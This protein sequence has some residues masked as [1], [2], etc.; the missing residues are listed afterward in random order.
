[1][2]L[3]GRAKRVRIYVNEGDVV[4]HKPAHLAILEFLRAHDTA[5]ATVLRAIEGFGGSGQI[6]TA[7]VVDAAF[8]LPIVIEWIDT[9]ERVAR[10]LPG[11]KQLV[12]RGLVT[13]DDTEVV[14]FSPQAVRDLPASLTV[15][16]VMVKAP[17]TVAADASIVGVV[18][19]LLEHEGHGAV[20]VV[21]GGVPVGIIT[22]S[23]F[24]SRGGAPIR[25]KLFTSL[26]EPER[27]LEL[28]RLGAVARTARDLM[29]APVTVRADAPLVDAAATMARKHLKRMPVVDES[30]R[31][32]GLLRRLDLLRTVA[33]RI[34]APESTAPPIEVATDTPVGSV[35]RSDV[36]AVHPDTPID[37][38]MQAVIAT[39]VYCAIVVDAD[40]RPLGIV[41]DAAML[42]RVTPALRPGAWRALVHR[43]PFGAPDAE[44]KA[45][46]QHARAR[47]AA[48]LMS[49]D[50]P[51]VAENA[52]VAEA[53]ASA[54]RAGY[55]VTAVV[56]GE[57]RLIGVADHAD[58]LRGLV[59]EKTSA[60]G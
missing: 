40:R 13:V 43:L 37:V 29:S 59:G 32:V 52:T 23:D 49:T 3:I 9:S 57:G 28:Q 6:H 5:G 39:D 27:R 18:E 20:C 7:R 14:L 38:V 42:E 34:D 16:D 58:M 24:L 15:A 36:P 30:G 17:P 2:D 22:S 60:R 35:L 4:Q 48:A 11:V 47:T 1:M 53:L 26:A 33:A 10:L 31:Q 54:M 19:A 55:R 56:D 50:L 51:R 44:T 45:S 12:R 21:E 8:Q 46:E 41:T 25:L